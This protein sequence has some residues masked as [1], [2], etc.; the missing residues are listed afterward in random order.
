M[1]E[2]ATGLTIYDGYR[3]TETVNIV[4]NY[5]CVPVKAGVDGKADARVRRQHCR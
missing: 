2:E 1:W 5:R 3:Q 4:A